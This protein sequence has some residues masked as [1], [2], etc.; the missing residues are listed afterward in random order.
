MHV[1]LE[2]KNK[3]NNDNIKTLQVIFSFLLL[4]VI[5][6]FL[7]QVH[8]LNYVFISSF[9]GQNNSTDHASWNGKNVVQVYL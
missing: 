8:I 4:I 6:V 3:Q 1:G 9:L 2:S 5:W 7:R